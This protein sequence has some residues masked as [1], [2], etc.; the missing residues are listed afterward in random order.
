MPSSITNILD[1]M[2]RMVNLPT[3]TQRIISLVPSQSELLYDLNLGDRVVGITKFCIHPKRWHQEK[4]RVGGTKNVDFAKIRQLKPDL[5]IGNKEENN[6]EDITKLAEL[7][8]VWMSNISNLNDAKKMIATL[9]DITNEQ[10]S[11]Q[12]IINTVNIEFENLQPIRSFKNALYL[13]WKAPYMCAGTDTFIDDM[14]SSCGFKNVITSQRY[15]QLS[16]DDIMALH[17]HY[18]FL[19]SEPYPFSEKHIHELKELSPQAEIILVDGEM[20]SWYGSRIQFAPSY[21]QSLIARL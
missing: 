12:R 7:Y 20:F 4:T 14:L 11:A 13:I 3:S 8:P 21:F 17:P 10:V 18:I 9:G 5:I 6:Q 15:P 2:G 19:S 16:S 1:Q